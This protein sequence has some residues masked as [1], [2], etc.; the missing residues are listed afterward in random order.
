MEDDWGGVWEE[1]GIVKGSYNIID[2]F[3]LSEFYC[4]DK[5]NV[6]FSKYKQ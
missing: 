4:D 1:G 3:I 2:R 6:V 5:V